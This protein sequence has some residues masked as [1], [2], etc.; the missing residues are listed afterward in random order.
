MHF[1]LHDLLKIIVGW[2]VHRVISDLGR[3]LVL[4]SVPLEIGHLV[5]VQWGIGRV[6]FLLRLEGNTRARWNFVIAEAVVLVQ[7]YLWTRV[8]MGFFMLMRKFVELRTGHVADHG[9]R[10]ALPHFVGGLE[11]IWKSGAFSHLL[12]TFLLDQTSDDFVVFFIRLLRVTIRQY[13]YWS[14]IFIGDWL[15]TAQFGEPD[16][17]TQEDFELCWLLDSWDQCQLLQVAL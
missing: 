16:V 9:A 7:I 8:G 1:L 10:R 12:Q 3:I 4:R 2:R 15:T 14:L 13:R 5:I 6:E 17:D 11:L